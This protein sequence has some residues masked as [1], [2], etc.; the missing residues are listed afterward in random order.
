MPDFHCYTVD[1]QVYIS[2]CPNDKSDQSRWDIRSWIWNDSLND[3]TTD[4]V[5]LGCHNNWKKWILLVF[6]LAMRTSNLCQLLEILARVLV[7]GILW[8]D[9]SQGYV[10]LHSSTST[11]FASLGNI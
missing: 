8:Q 11:I 3:D 1:T 2:F 10:A 9:T 7:R 4:S 5:L 6:V